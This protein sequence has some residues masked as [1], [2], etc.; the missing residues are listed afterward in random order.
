MGKKMLVYFNIELV[1]IA[2]VK[3]SRWAVSLLILKNF[4]NL[5]NFDFVD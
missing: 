3:N 4:H 5:S 1:K 2:T